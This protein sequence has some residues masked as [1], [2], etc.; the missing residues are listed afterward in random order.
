MIDILAVEDYRPISYSH[1]LEDGIEPVSVSPV[2]YRSIL[3]EEPYSL[4]QAM[5]LGE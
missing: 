2:D 4:R 5:L 1:R 3:H